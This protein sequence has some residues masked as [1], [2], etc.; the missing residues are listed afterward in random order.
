MS[1]RVLTV[2]LVLLLSFGT[3]SA[4]SYTSP[5]SLLSGSL[6]D[7]EGRAEAELIDTQF[8]PVTFSQFTFGG[9][10]PQIDN[11]PFMFAYG[12]SSGVAVLTG[13]LEGGHPFPT[14]AGIQ[15]TFSTTMS[16]VELFFSDT[17]PLGSYLV[18][19]FDSGSALLE[20]ILI[21]FV[22][23][24]TPMSL[25]AGFDR[26]AG[27]IASVRVGPS[28]SSG[29]AFAIDDV[30]FRNRCEGPC[31]DVPEPTVLALLG[32]G[33]IGLAALRRRRKP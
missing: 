5:V 12:A 6:I 31:R 18:Q 1:I 30:R 20:S 24:G 9:G 19:A 15:M 10:R 28:S 8:P 26:G 7:F 4:S 21:S 23:S 14:V 16:D 2:V 27:D 29:D 3:A 33:L 22:D 17:V 13:S 32:T 11:A 25:F